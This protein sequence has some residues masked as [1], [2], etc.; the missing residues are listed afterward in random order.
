MAA[1]E[2]TRDEVEETARNPFAT[3]PA[4]HRRTHY[5]KTI[6]GNS[7]R[8]TIAHAGREDVVVSVWKEPLP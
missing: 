5:F 2:A 8:V 1:R 7:I 4:R 6:K 3:R